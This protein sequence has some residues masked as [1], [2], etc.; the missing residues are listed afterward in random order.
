[1]VTQHVSADWLRI[2]LT[3]SGLYSDSEYIL[4]GT[5]NA[6]INWL[7]VPIKEFFHH[8][9]REHFYDMPGLYMK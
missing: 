7:F 8:Y 3:L 2:T 9:P 5:H 6:K 4:N 1:M